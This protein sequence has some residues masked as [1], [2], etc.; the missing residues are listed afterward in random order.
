[1][2]RI[3]FTPQLRRFV[4]A[5][6]VDVDAPTLHEAL[7]AAFARHPRLRGY[8]LD[9]QGH[10]RPNVVI[11]VDGRRSDDRAKQAD[12]LSPASEVYVMQALSGG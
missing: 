10:V 7:D 1:M 11:F 6:T 12:A 3:H 9:E 2:A 5:P 4:D 8:V